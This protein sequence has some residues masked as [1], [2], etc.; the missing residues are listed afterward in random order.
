MTNTRSGFEE[1]RSRLQLG[2]DCAL[3]L[4]GQAMILLPRHFFRYIL[5]EVNSA[6]S[7]EAYRKILWT[8]G[9]DGAVTFCCRFQ[10]VH[11]CTP[12]QAVEGYLDEMSLRGWGQFTILRLAPQAGEMEVALRNSALAP[13]GDLPSGNIIW[14]G[15]M[16]GAMV[17][18]REATGQP[19]EDSLVSR[20]EMV[21]E[22]ETR[23]FHI[24][25]SLDSERKPAP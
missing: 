6:A 21:A 2:P 12:D 3:T 20:G 13:E 14:E 11:G 5:R 19:L 1:L 17:F 22:G 23:S 15:A 10:E 9:R 16:C 8:A 24:V 4:N 25:V 7:P 18:L